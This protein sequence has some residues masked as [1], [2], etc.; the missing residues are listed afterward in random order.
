MS[1]VDGGEFGKNR[2]H[3]SRVLEFK[4]FIENGA[5]NWA[6]VFGSG[7]YVTHW[8]FVVSEMAT[9]SHWQ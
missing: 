5:E 1:V 9:V 8:L 4:Y 6:H 3:Q 7:A 2:L